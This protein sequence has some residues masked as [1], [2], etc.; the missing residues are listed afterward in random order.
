MKNYKEIAESIIEYVG[1]KENITSHTHCMTRLRFVLADTG[2]V[3]EDAIKALPEVQGIVNKAG[4]YQ[5]VI[6]P[7]VDNLYDQINLLCP[8]KDIDEKTVDKESREEKKS[9]FNTVL[10]YVSGS[11]A[12]ALSVL[13][14]AG[15]TSAFLT[16]FVQFGWLSNESPTYLIFNQLQSLGF[17]YLPVM[18]AFGAAKRLKTNEYLAA[19]II[20]V[21][22]SEVIT[23][24]EGLSLFGIDLM[25]VNY[26]SN[27]VPAL[28]M[29]PIMAIIDK[30]ITCYIPNVAKAAFKPFVL[31]ILT[32]IITI[33]IIG[34]LGAIV[35]N[36]L[37]EFCIWISGFGGFSMGILSAL[38]PILVMFGVHTVL[39][40]IFISETALYGYSILSAK[41]L[42]G[43]FAMAGAA[44]AVG[45]KARKLENK[46]SSITAGVTAL[47]SVTEPALYGTLLRL[48]KPFIGAIIG[49]GLSGIALGLF[50]VKC[51]AGGP[52]TVFTMALYMGGDSMTNFYLACLCAV[53]AV[54]FGFVAT[55]LIGFDEE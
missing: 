46:S 54:V 44:L 37:G 1:G 5:L 8:I 14:T 4:Q 19:F 21:L 36:L 24:V 17:T 34:P 45:L 12:P 26:A 27:I 35:G 47:L 31:G 22:S 48:R 2:K 20:L 29:V 13:I 39:T 43:N 52:S 55:W 51:Y 38:H 41:A 7:E 15:F 9:L 25:T 49:A 10:S 16:L 3:H 18:V 32:F 40:P 28:C 6:G 50:N 42:A 33:F 30:K 11:I 23:G 53:L